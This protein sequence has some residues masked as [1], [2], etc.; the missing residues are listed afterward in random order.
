[1][2]FPSAPSPTGRLT[3]SEPNWQHLPTVHGRIS[4]PMPL[5]SRQREV[6]ALL[7]ND[8]L[9]FN[10]RVLTRTELM[11]IFKGEQLPRDPAL[12]E[13]LG[14]G[15][16]NA[17]YSALEQRAAAATGEPARYVR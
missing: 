17:D 3:A 12:C 5:N 10:G 6:L 14:M 2:N 16:L 7:Q 13:F 9:D 1:M 15:Y 11:S 4:L 8:Q